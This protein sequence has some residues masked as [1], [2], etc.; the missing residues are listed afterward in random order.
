MCK[1]CLGPQEALRLHGERQRPNSRPPGCFRSSLGLSPALGPCLHWT[2]SRAGPPGVC[3][4]QT[5]R[6]GLHTV[7]WNHRIISLAFPP[8][9]QPQPAPL[10]CPTAQRR[11]VPKHWKLPRIRGK[12]G[13]SIGWSSSH[14]ERA[15]HT[16][17]CN[18]GHRLAAAGRRFRLGAITFC[19]R[20]A[21][22]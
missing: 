14:P 13:D 19:L 18:R 1:G 5:L 16:D 3:R 12:N 9:F 2:V 22:S 7:C 11:S 20:P 4:P 10:I 15:S 6:S 8:F 21:V 17:R